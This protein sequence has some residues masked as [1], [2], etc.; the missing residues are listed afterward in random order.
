MENK[1]KKYTSRKILGRIY[2]EVKTVDFKPR[3]DMVFDQRVL[4]RFDLTDEILKK[5]RVLKSKYD[6]AMRRLMGQKEVST[7]FEMW[8]AFVLTK[9]RIGTDYKQ[10]EDIRHESVVIK[11][12]FRDLAVQEAGSKD[13][14]VLAPFV[15]AMY[16][17]TFEEV[18]IALF[19]CKNVFKD[20]SDWRGKIRPENMP[21]IS[22]P[23]LFDTELGKIATGPDATEADE[24]LGKDHHV[25]KG[26]KVGDKELTLEDIQK[27]Q[28]VRTNQGVV[29]HRG[30]VLTMLG[31]SFHDH[32]DDGFD[33]D[34]PG[35]EP[36]Q[37]PDVVRPYEESVDALGRLPTSN[38][39]PTPG[40]TKP[41]SADMPLRVLPTNSLVR[42]HESN[43]GGPAENVK[44]ET[45]SD[46]EAQSHSVNNS[47]LPRES[48]GNENAL[49][50]P[51]AESI[52]TG[53]ES[54]A[55]PDEAGNEGM[56]VAATPSIHNATDEDSDDENPM[57]RAIRLFG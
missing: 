35:V 11:T 42:G 38:A 31:S 49:E 39:T 51:S 26:V 29:L 33:V 21:L 17:V 56:T 52:A 16:Q 20:H 44:M 30:Q 36:G 2:D 34:A 48:K 10:A 28:Y 8:T 3:Y 55:S 9:P 19:E 14:D 53:T 40:S 13:F 46:Q 4:G 6:T 25:S 32:D 5:A 27:M 54:S 22:F 24:T 15:A 41:S 37:V 18:K 47:D 7:E 23:W 45:M 1:K 50:R 12:Q 57:M 43:A